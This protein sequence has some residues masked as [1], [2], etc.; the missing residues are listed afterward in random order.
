MENFVITFARGF[1]TGGKEIASKLAK[2]LGIH[3]YE[4]RILTLAS[5][6]SGLDENVF[7][8]VNEKVVTKNGF[9]SFLKG[10]PRAKTYIARNEKF[11]SDDKLFEYQSTIIRNLA[12]QESCV[13]V[14]KCADYVLRDKQNVVSVYIEA[15]RDFCVQRTIEHMGV[16]L[17]VA[18]AT[19]TQTD[20]FRADYYKY[21]TQGNYWTNPV[22]YDM[23]LNSAR[24]GIDDCVRVI[25][26]YLVL[27]GY[28]TRDMIKRD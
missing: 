2:D 16:T 10:L 11:V 6:L 3:C 1:G 28:I 23:T 14:G 4:N 25:E 24:V 26:D 19:I 18:N 8:Q 21:Y 5:Q 20:K 15:P 7:R 17:E 12:E 27:K 9:G 22:N 13:I